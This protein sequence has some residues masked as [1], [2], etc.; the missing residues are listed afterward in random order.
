M[1]KF[2]LGLDRTLSVLTAVVV[3]AMMLHVVAHAL[4]RYFFNA[5]I[6]GTNEIVAYWYLPAIALLGIPAATLQREHISVTLAVE[7]MGNNARVIWH[8]FG[9]AIG[10]LLSLGFAWF[11]LEEA[12]EKMHMGA[13]AGVTDIITWP[14]YFLVPAVFAILAILNV[15][16]AFYVIRSKDTSISLRTGQHEDQSS[17]DALVA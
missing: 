11:G 12:L 7:A 6:Y 2:N 9:N 4:L 15:I 13:T 8:V 17:E 10:V 14:M 16:D 3:I 1:V 5:P